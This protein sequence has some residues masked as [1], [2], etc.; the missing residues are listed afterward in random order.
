MDLCHLKHSEL[1]EHP[2]KYNGRVVLRG[3]DGKRTTE[4]CKAVFAEQGASAHQLTGAN[5]LDT[6]FRP[7]GNVLEKR[8]RQFRLPQTSEWRMFSN[9]SSFRRRSALKFG[10]GSVVIVVR[11]TE[12]TTSMTHGVLEDSNFHGHP[13][14]GFLWERK[15]AAIQLQEDR[16]PHKVWNACIPSNRQIVLVNVCRGHQDGG[17]KE[18]LGPMWAK[19]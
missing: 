15:L 4:E 3:D 5:V 10:Y 1:A 2:Y 7:P 18:S 11:Q 19:L 12:R 6:I 8:T 14:A 13:L 17:R 9:C 16:G